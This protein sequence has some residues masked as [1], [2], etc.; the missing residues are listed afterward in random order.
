MRSYCYKMARIAIGGILFGT[1][2][3]FAGLAHMVLFLLGFAGSVTGR[4]NGKIA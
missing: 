3:I 2:S 4:T 1:F